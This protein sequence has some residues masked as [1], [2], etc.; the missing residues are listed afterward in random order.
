MLLGAALPANGGGPATSIQVEHVMT[1]HAALE[2]PRIADGNLSVFN[3]PGGWVGPWMV[4]ATGGGAFARGNFTD[5]ATFAAPAASSNTASI[6]Q[7]MAGWTVGGGAEWMFAPQWSL[8]AEYLYADL[9]HVSA[10]SAN[11]LFP[12]ATIRHDHRLT[13]NI[14]RLGV[15]WHF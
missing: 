10:T 7:T 6:D 14:A 5:T 13:E 9:G 2:A 8:K 1:L 3:A 4:Y 15:D 12:L 11:T